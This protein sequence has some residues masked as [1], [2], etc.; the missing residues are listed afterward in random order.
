MFSILTS[1]TSIVSLVKKATSTSF[2]AVRISC[3]VNFADEIEKPHRVIMKITNDITCRRIVSLSYGVRLNYSPS[4]VPMNC[5][6]SDITYL[7][8]LNQHFSTVWDKFSQADIFGLTHMKKQSR[9]TAMVILYEVIMMQ[10][11][12]TKK[13]ANCNYSQRIYSNA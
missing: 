1:L 10:S 2:E 12:N 9:T 5:V 13:G 4:S 6:Q 3:K 8:L 7:Q 11:D